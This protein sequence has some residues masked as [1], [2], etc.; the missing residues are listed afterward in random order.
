M[1][2][3]RCM[4]VLIR[5]L[6][7][8][9]HQHLNWGTLYKSL[10][11]KRLHFSHMDSTLFTTKND[12]YHQ[13]CSQLCKKHKFQMTTTP[14]ISI[15]IGHKDALFI[16]RQLARNFDQTI[17]SSCLYNNPVIEEGELLDE[18]FTI[19]DSYVISDVYDFETYLYDAVDFN[20]VLLHST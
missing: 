14:M 19:I 17:T 11:N 20:F 2:H 16:V 18:I 10:A 15:G 7:P 3:N 1:T 13:T 6:L 8:L 4:D 5:Q 9:C 12:I